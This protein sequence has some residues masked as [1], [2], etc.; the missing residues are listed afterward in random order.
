MQSRLADN[1]PRCRLKLYADKIYNTSPLVTAAWSLRHGPI[2]Q[3]MSDENWVMSKIRVAIEW[4]FG[5]IL[6]LFKFVDFAKGQ[7]K[8]SGTSAARSRLSTG[9]SATIAVTGAR[10]PNS[11]GT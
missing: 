1:P 6:M 4:T 5:S 8:S 11:W 7:K 10:L 9:K 2:A 3:W